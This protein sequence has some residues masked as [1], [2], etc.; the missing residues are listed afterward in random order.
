MVVVALQAAPL[1]S[2]S[3]HDHGSPVASSRAAAAAQCHPHLPAE[4]MSSSA[5]L[6]ASMHNM[7]GGPGGLPCM[8]SILKAQQ[9][10]TKGR[11]ND[12]G[13][14]SASYKE[15]HVMTRLLCWRSRCSGV[16]VCLPSGALQ[17][18]CPICTSSEFNSG[19]M[20]SR[21][22][23]KQPSPPC[24]QSCK[25]NQDQPCRILR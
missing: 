6:S 2:L 23:P 10:C 17:L 3:R 19:C 11:G 18:S 1:R 13:C 8:L 14:A 12:T 16:S 5:S 20:Q 25:M 22:L 21:L 9:N 24:M 7:R 15:E 4:R